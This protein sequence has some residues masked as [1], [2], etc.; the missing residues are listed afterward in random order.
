[1]NKPNIANYIIF[2]LSNHFIDTQKENLDNELIGLL[3]ENW[4]KKHFIPAPQKNIC[5]HHD[6]SIKSSLFM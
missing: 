5:H 2:D 3:A 4:H 6:N 1:M